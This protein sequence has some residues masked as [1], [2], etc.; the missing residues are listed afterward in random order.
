MSWMNILENFQIDG[1]FWIERDGKIIENE[2]PQYEWIR[3]HRKLL[4][5][6]R[7]CPASESVQRDARSHHWKALRHRTSCCTLEELFGL[8]IY[9]LESNGPAYNNCFVNALAEKAKNGGELVFGS[10]G[11]EREDGSVFWEYGN[12]AW[13]TYDKFFKLT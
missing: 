9:N 10:M 4:N 7:H 13:D 11:W 6:R 8:C 3:K 12:P 1:H 2:F 5:K